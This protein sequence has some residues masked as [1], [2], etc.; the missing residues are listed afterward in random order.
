MLCVVGIFRSMTFSNLRWTSGATA[1]VYDVDVADD[2]IFAVTGES[3]VTGVGGDAPTVV[4]KTIFAGADDAAGTG[5][6]VRM[7]DGFTA[8]R[9]TGT[10]GDE[11]A[12]V[13]PLLLAGV[14]DVTFAGV[15]VGLNDGVFVKVPDG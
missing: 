6:I 9:V 1:G 15:I 3:E 5:A 12:G 7:F 2:E 14:A 4:T 10:I 8:D 13:T 11:V